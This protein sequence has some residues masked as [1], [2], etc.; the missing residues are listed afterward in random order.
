LPQQLQQLQQHLQTL[1]AVVQTRLFIN[2]LLALLR[3]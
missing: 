1:L 2:R 3:I